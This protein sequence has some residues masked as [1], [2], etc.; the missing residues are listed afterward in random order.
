M[1]ENL[2]QIPVLDTFLLFFQGL[3]R[4]LH[5]QDYNVVYHLNA[6][7]V[8]RQPPILRQVKHNRSTDAYSINFYVSLSSLGLIDGN[9]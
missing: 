9:V 8:I 1:R 4:L 7:K 5:N 2:L 6:T 3:D